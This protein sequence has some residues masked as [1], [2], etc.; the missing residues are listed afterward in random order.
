MENDSGSWVIG[1]TVTRLVGQYLDYRTATHPNAVRWHGGNGN[2]ATLGVGSDGM[3]YT[4]GTS[5]SSLGAAVGMSSLLVV[6]A[7]VVGVIFLKSR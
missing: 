7:L 1:D 4:R 6:A 3:V 5:S 2:G